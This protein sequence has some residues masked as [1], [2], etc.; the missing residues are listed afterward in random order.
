MKVSSKIIFLKDTLLGS[1]LRK[2]RCSE[3]LW[4]LTITASSSSIAIAV[5]VEFS[6]DPVD[7]L[8][9]HQG[10][11]SGDLAEALVDRSR[12]TQ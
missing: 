7:E 4:P 12:Q 9:E 2:V 3:P 11:W 1:E 6:D 8:P 5:R 10:E